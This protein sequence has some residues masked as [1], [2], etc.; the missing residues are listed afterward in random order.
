MASE[1]RESQ[2]ALRFFANRQR[3]EMPTN[4]WRMQAAFNKW[5]KVHR[6]WN[7]DIESSS[8]SQKMSENFL[9]KLFYNKMQLKELLC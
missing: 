6:N 9:L 5:G 4:A 7:F 1:G 8:Q 3:N 2:L